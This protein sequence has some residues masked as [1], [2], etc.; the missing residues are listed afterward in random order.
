MYLTARLDS[1]VASEHPD[2]LQE[3]QYSVQR[4]SL[5]WNGEP[6]IKTQLPTIQKLLHCSQGVP[7]VNS[8]A[9]VAALRLNY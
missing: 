9:N 7:K 3:D 2:L 4:Q 6:L 8:I 5:K 1:N